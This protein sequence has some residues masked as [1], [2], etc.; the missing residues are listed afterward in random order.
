MKCCCV[1]LFYC[2]LTLY[3]ANLIRNE[4]NQPRMFGWLGVFKKSKKQNCLKKIYN[5]FVFIWIDFVTILWWAAW[6]LCVCVCVC[7]VYGFIKKSKLFVAVFSLKEITRKKSFFLE[8]KKNKIKQNIL[9]HRKRR[10]HS[11]MLNLCKS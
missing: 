6:F 5:L 1:A 9:L 11:I 3:S 10:D 8:K 4:N 7:Y 2:F